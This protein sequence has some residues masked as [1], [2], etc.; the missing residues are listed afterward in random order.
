M[1][2]KHYRRFM[3]H[4]DAL[5]T[6]STRLCAVAGCS[7][8]HKAKNF[9]AYHYS[10]HHISVSR[11]CRVEGCMSKSRARGL[12]Q[13]HYTR[14]R[15]Y[16]DENITYNVITSSPEES[17]ILTTN[18]TFNFLLLVAAI[19]IH[20]YGRIYIIVKFKIAHRYAWE[21]LHGKLD[22]SLHI[23]HICHN[24]ACV[25]IKHIRPATSHQNNA[26]RIGPMSGSLSGVRNVHM[27]RD[28]WRV[29]VKKH[30]KNYHFGRFRTV[31]EAAVVA[32]QARQDLFGDYA[33]RG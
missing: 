12:C 30:G 13:K 7:R 31:E 24:K 18:S 10:T 2:N 19:Y 15:V 9:C 6:P 28:K 23:D 5:Y 22:D 3:K 16:V 1:C 21:L 17:Y 20:G 32:E 11:Q 26:N 25:N 8:K 4:G 27:D 14:Y 29:T 33:G